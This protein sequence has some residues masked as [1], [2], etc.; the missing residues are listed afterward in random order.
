MVIPKGDDPI[1]DN[2]PIKQKLDD[3][4]RRLS[5]EPS[6]E[7]LTSMQLH[8]DL[9]ER[10]ARIVSTTEADHQ[11]NHMNDHD[12]TAFVEPLVVLSKEKAQQR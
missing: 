10:W 2:D 11:H 12:N 8:I 5:G 4:R 3:I 9:L 1:K 7:E 6:Y